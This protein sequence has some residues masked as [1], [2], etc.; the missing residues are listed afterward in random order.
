MN[1][2]ERSVGARGRN[3]LVIEEGGA[4]RS[5]DGGG[6]LDLA[7]IRS[8]LWRERFVLVACIAVALVLGVIATLLTTPEYRAYASIQIEETGGQIVEGQDI[9]PEVRP[10]DIL[11]FMATLTQVIESQSMALAVVDELQLDQDQSFIGDSLP[12]RYTTLPEDQ[13][14]ALR[15][16]IAAE[17]LSDNVMPEPVDRTRV[18]RI[19]YKSED[20]ALTARVANAYV[21]S[22]LLSELQRGS[23]VNSYAREILLEQIEQVRESLQEAESEAIEYARNN[24]I[25]GQPISS[26]RSASSGGDAG[27]GSEPVG[28]AQ[29]ISGTN[30]VTVNETY[31]AARIRR[32]EAEQRW[33]AVRDMAP[34]Q[35]PEVQ[36]NPVV[37]GLIAQKSEIERRLNELRERYREDYPEVAQLRAQLTSIDRNIA[38]IANDVKSV[39]RDEYRIAQ[40]QENGLLEELNSVSDSAIEEQSRRVQFNI[41]NRDV[42]ALQDQLDS[43]LNRFNQISSAANIDS[44]RLSSLDPAQVPN[45]AYS[46]NLF[47]N[48]LIALLLGTGLGVGLTIMRQIFDDRVR[49][50]RDVETKLGVPL[51]GSIPF[52]EGEPLQ[53]VSEPHSHVAEAYSAL[54]VAIDFT[55]GRKSH[56]VLQ[57]TSSSPSEGKSITSIA[58][59]SD[60]A[61]AGRRVLL[62]DTDLRKPSLGKSLRT[63][64]DDSERGFMNVLSKDAPIENE[65]LVNTIENLDVLPLGP[66]PPNPVQLLSSDLLPKFIERYRHSYDIII[67]DTAPVIGLADSPIVSHHVDATLFVVEANRAHYGQAKAAMRRLLDVG[68]N[69]IGGVLTKYRP[70]EAGDSYSYSY[71]YYAYGT[72]TALEQKAN[73][74][75]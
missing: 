35:V 19:G 28:T 44:S 26:S 32:I 63:P 46:P 45:G 52:T 25:V 41:L 36:S 51:L 64:D 70:L 53:S 21:E 3:D 59:A 71:S 8:I 10:N 6:L 9:D 66:L 33:L 39:I 15:R 42:T 74:R 56:P 11:V 57:V 13:R 16:K 48:L 30:L 12:E 40:R 61:R 38:S 55:L 50:P 67:L 62:V 68:A 72:P 31:A 2:D 20:Q 23:E 49:S 54:R 69:V 34:M 47:A 73:A 43:L 27:G 65:M 24:G 75:K 29:T 18:M 58:L 5:D 7:Y 17:K 22:L 37:Q 1:A 60:Y 14:A 4:M